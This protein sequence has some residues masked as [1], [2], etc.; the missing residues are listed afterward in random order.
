LT[1]SVRFFL[2]RALSPR[3]Q[4]SSRWIAVDASTRRTAA[5]AGKDGGSPFLRWLADGAGEDGEPEFERAFG[6]LGLERT[7]AGDGYLEWYRRLNFDYPFVDYAE[8]AGRIT[9]AHLM[10]SYLASEEQPP[11][12]TAHPGPR[13][14]LDA[15]GIELA[16]G[17]PAAPSEA[18]LGAWLHAAAGYNAR[19]AGR[20]GPVLH[21]TSPSGGARHPT[22]V[23]VVLGSAW[24]E[25]A[26]A[27]WYD[28]DERA[29]VGAEPPAG[30]GLAPE[31]AVFVV[32]SHVTRAMWRYR[33]VRAFRPVLYD[34]GHVV[35]TLALLLG[36]AGWSARWTLRPSFGSGP[37]GLDA[38][39]GFLSAGPDGAADGSPAAPD[40]PSPGEGALRTNPFLSVAYEDGDLLAFNHLRPGD[41]LRVSGPML[42]ALAYAIPS[43]RGDRPTQPAQIAEATAVPQEGIAAL[44][45][46]GLLIEEEAGTRL[47]EGLGP[48]TRNDWYL[49]ALVHA[50]A[51]ASEGRPQ[52]AAS[53]SPWLLSG[54][55][56]ALDRRRTARDLAAEPLPA[57]VAERLTAAIREVRGIPMVLSTPTGLGELGPG[58]HAIEDGAG[59]RL[60]AEALPAELVRR[61]A[62]GQ[63]WAHGFS[64]ALW[65]LPRVA[66]ADA[67]AWEAHLIECG[68]AA[69]RLALAASAA[70]EVGVFQTPAMVDGDLERLL[71][72]GCSADGAYLIGI[73]LSRGAER[74]SRSQDLVVSDL[75]RAVAA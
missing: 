5:I 16:A 55:P 63:P 9:D 62:I 19:S 73:G 34:A 21:R 13:R 50:E 15:G 36:L 23:G 31:A 20:L 64:A 18:L 39:L 65:L 14:P 7:L 28:P 46:A 69:Q 30:S 45:E 53:P 4:A 1:P 56:A 71:P 54:L 6:D 27:W 68:R 22:D 58:V 51:S 59:E 17:S 33:D 24:E 40:P 29:L 70:P 61:T 52:P 41:R 42:D 11:A 43:S 2:S 32:S 72:G 66:G 35:E 47:W 26:G 75:L 12:A 25:L 74:D 44:T 10:D 48:W 49:S 38:V 57:A 60:R 3:V 37:D 67:A 8:A